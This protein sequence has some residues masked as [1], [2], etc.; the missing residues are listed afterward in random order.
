MKNTEWVDSEWI[1]VGKNQEV[2]DNDIIEVNVKQLEIKAG[3]TFKSKLQ[4][5][6]QCSKHSKDR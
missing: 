5:N 6:R 2:K 1:L 4:V 3:D